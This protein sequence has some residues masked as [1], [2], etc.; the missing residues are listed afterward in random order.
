MDYSLSGMNAPDVI[1]I[2]GKGVAADG[3]VPEI[4]RHQID[5]AIQLCEHQPIQALLFSG[6]YWGLRDNLSTITEAAAMKQYAECVCPTQ[7]Q[8]RIQ[9]LTEQQSKDTIGNMVFTKAIIDRH[10]W[11]NIL[12]MSTADHLARVHYIAQRVFGAGY[13]IHYHG[14]QHMITPPQYRYVR[15]YEWIAWQYAQLFFWRRGANLQRHFMYHSNWLR[16][17]LRVIVARPAHR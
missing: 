3:T 7:L 12:I 2:L 6:E 13:T 9:F 5:Y 11:K 8:A 1:I 4:V 16:T 10:H 17:W 15:R 14:H